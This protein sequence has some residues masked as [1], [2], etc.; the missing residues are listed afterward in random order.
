MRL[1][2][3]TLT[4]RQYLAGRRRVSIWRIPRQDPMSQHRHEFFEIALVVSGTGV[5]A[6]GDVRHRIAMGDV[7][8]LNPRRTHGYEECRG[9]SLVNVLIRDDTLRRL[10]RQLRQPDGF[11]ELF[12]REKVRW[13]KTTYVMRLRLRPVDIELVDR[14]IARIEDAA[15]S[16]DSAIIDAC[17]LLI[18]DLLCRTW[19]KAANSDS[20]T[21]HSKSGINRVLEFFN[22]RLGQQVTIAEA[23]RRCGMSR[24]SFFR[25]FGEAMGMSPRAYL[26]QMRMRR[27]VDLLADHREDRTIAEISAACGFPDSNYFSR[28]FKRF[29]GVSPG[30]YRD[31]R[32]SHRS[33]PARRALSRT[34]ISEMR[35]SK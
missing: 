12:E 19:A 34:N 31:V 6:T 16:G 8:V 27:A 11:A 9:L 14:H 26:E 13:R 1:P 3:P 17:L 21:D 29:A 35:R 28:C 5:H 15:A 20:V 25:L 30:E 32:S 2:P 4:R 23:A 33:A 24:R 18:V 22:A 7:L 10:G